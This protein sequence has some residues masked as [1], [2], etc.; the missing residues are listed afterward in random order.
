MLPPLQWGCV[1]HG[2]KG[3][4][5]LQTFSPPRVL[6]YTPSALSCHVD[7]LEAAGKGLHQHLLHSRLYFREQ[8]GRVRAQGV[9]V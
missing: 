3:N 8:K 6:L 4:A 2:V 5:S 9:C 1:R 7:V